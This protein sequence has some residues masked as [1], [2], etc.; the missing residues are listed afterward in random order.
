[1]KKKMLAVILSMTMA[2]ALL[3]GCGNEQKESSAAKEPAA[4]EQPATQAD[5]PQAAKEP[6]EAGDNASSEENKPASGLVEGDFTIGISQFAQHGSLDNCREGFLTGL[7]EEGFIEGE[8]LTVEYQNAE[9]DMG[10]V[11]QIPQ[12]FV[13]NKV[14]LICA[15]ATPAAQ[16]AY[17]AA[18]NSGIPVIYT[19][20]NDPVGAELAKEDG[21]PVGEVTGTS[22]KLPVDA[23]LKM[24]RELLPDAKKIGIMYTTSEVNSESTIAEY[25]AA[26]GQYGFELVTTGINTTA[27]APLA[28]DNLLSKVDCLN[29]LTDNTVVSALPTI[30]DKANT[31]KIPVFGSEVEQVKIGCLASE[32]IDYYQLGIKT[33]KMAAQV[34]KG[35][36]KASEIKMETI[37]GSELYLNT[38]VADDLGISLP[39][40][41]K[42]R[43]SETFTEIQTAE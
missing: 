33:G 9:A 40:D 17:N 3:G 21:M 12:G 11:N 20:V 30:L 37:T 43:A 32:G 6:E 18:M 13:S 25:E 22:D 8:N 23:Q 2:A 15:I 26:V 41:V 7:A 19:A 29:N 42:S 10:I 36:K 4:T 5:D 34:L 24:I 31:Q 35:E 38:K 39:D 28:A 16:S 1:M 14:D 27:D